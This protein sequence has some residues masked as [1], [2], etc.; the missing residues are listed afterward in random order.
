MNRKNSKIVTL[1]MN[2]VLD[3]TANAKLVVPE[4]KIRCESPTYAPGGGGLNVSRAI[5]KLGGKSQALL[6]SGGDN[7]KRIIDLLEKENIRCK[8]IKSG[9]NTRE[10]VMV[11]EKNTG[12][13]Y[14]FVMPGPKME[15]KQWEKV[16]DTVENLT[17]KPEYLVASGS[18]PPG[19]PA[20][21]YARVA[22]IANKNKYRFIL[23][24]SGPPMKLAME[25]GVFLLKPNL[26]EIREMLNKDKLTGM[27]L[28][29]TA[30]EMLDKKYC[31]ILVVSLGA[32][33]AMLAYNN[34]VE[35]IVPPSMPVKSAVGA[36]DSMV[37]GILT[38]FARNKSVRDS[39][40][41]GI[42]AGTAAAMTP[43]SELCK[44]EDTEKI[45]DWL[46]TRYNQE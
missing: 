31:S 11:F 1:T 32:K 30:T 6:F 5:K 40:C 3:K 13:L 19:V 9:Q 23:D 22:S 33:G 36:G 25:E 7:G 8:Q 45:Y 2:P 28:E 16:L 44:K 39:V 10:N 20:D 18:L 34:K 29:D 27:E 37:A 24:T 12:H 43:G 41:Y 38:G 46:K 17:P 21:F 35:H 4:K 42:S 14:R 15:E 26:R